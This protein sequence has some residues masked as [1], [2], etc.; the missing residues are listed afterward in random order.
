MDLDEERE[1]A[2]E[3]WVIEA[4]CEKKRTPPHITRH[5]ITD[6]SHTLEQS[7]VLVPFA[8]PWLSQSPKQKRGRIKADTAIFW[9]R[10]NAMS[11]G[12]NADGGCRGRTQT[13]AAQPRQQRRLAHTTA[14]SGAACLRQ[15]DSL[16]DTEESHDKG[17]GDIESQLQ[18]STLVGNGQLS[19]RGIG[20][21]PLR[22]IGKSSGTR[23]VW[24][25]Y[26][27]SYWIVSDE[28]LHIKSRAKCKEPTQ[29]TRVGGIDTEPS[30]DWSIASALK[31]RERSKQ[32][33]MAKQCSRASEVRQ[34][35]N[36]RTGGIGVCQESG[37]DTDG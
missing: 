15:V 31:R 19:S 5:K 20:I 9:G 25:G 22:L 1:L 10:S 3:R 16:K 7:S 8:L 37:A 17:S 6:C 27:R 23:A 2:F 24:K 34:Y 11:S 28:E 4:A 36:A 26:W 35:V 18:N 29:V 30:E 32:L 12:R 33:S 14:D 21:W 13:T